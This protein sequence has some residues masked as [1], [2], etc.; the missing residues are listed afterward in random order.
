MALKLTEMEQITVAV[1]E[2]ERWRRRLS[3]RVPAAAVAAAREE[4]AR[5]L[6]G[7]LKLPGFRKGHVPHELVEKRYGDTLRREMLDRVIGDAYR[8]ALTR[9]ALHPISEGHVES[10]DYQPESDLTFSVAFDVAPVLQVGRLGGFKVSRPV[11]SVDETHVQRVIERLR[12]QQ[13]V[14]RPLDGGR[15]QAGEL[16]AIEMVALESE[17]AT[18]VGDTRTYELVLGAGDAIPDVEA[19]IATLEVGQSNEFSV[20][21]PDDFPDEARRG[22]ER[23]VRISLLSRKERELPVLDD[24]FARSLG[25]F[26]GLD[27]LRAKIREDLERDARDQEEAAVRARILDSLVDA[28]AFEVP[29]SMVDRYLDRMLGN[30]EGVPQEK[31]AE[32]REALRADATRQVKRALLME[33]VAEREGLAATE[34]EVDERVQRIAERSERTA[35]EVYAQLQRASRIEGLRR[36]ITEDKTF[37]F[38]KAKSDIIPETVP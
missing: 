32:A 30:P 3:V 13:G 31:L 34:Q 7:R 33:H 6:A 35:A 9:E 23:R 26:T 10:V 28:N 21:F 37:E 22:Q 14:W 1:E 38:L 4:V 16:V 12:E 29:D 27:D 24:D 18:Q 17:G 15:A 11:V 25:K 5:D 2:R 20:R 8:E 19:A 36:E